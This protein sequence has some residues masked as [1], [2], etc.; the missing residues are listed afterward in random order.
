MINIT[1]ISYYHCYSL[2]SYKV[3][4]GR[5]DHDPPIPANVD[6]ADMRA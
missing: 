1:I 4:D 5:D 6:T 2:Y 3:D